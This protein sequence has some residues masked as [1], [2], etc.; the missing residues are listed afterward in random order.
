[1]G[2]RRIG[3]IVLRFGVEASSRTEEDA[4]A[5][6]ALASVVEH[7]EETVCTVAPASAVV[8]TRGEGGRFRP[9]P[10]AGR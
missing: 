7:L 1:V 4:T 2:G 5:R 8:L 9:I 3:R 6:R 10:A